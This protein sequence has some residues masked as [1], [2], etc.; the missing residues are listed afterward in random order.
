M[1]MILGFRG[2]SAQARHKGTNKTNAVCVNRII[3]IYTLRL[4]HKEPF[5]IE[6]SKESFLI[7]VERFNCVGCKLFQLDR[8]FS[9]VYPTAF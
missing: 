7:F 1:R 5:Q 4:W 3:Q 9:V 8:A 2:T 6:I